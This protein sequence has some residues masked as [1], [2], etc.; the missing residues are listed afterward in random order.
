MADV[1]NVLYGSTF[2][3]LAVINSYCVELSTVYVAVLQL[4]NA[5][6]E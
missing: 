2:M 3:A 5:E 4:L 6:C 1:F